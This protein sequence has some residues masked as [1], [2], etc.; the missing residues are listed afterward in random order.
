MNSMPLRSEY[1]HQSIPELRAGKVALS[2]NENKHQHLHLGRGHCTFP[3]PIPNISSQSLQSVTFYLNPQLG[4]EGPPSSVSQSLLTV[5]GRRRVAEEQPSSI[6]IWMSLLFT[7]DWNQAQTADPDP[8]SMAIKRDHLV[9][10][11]LLLNYVS[12]P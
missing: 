11:I 1:N 7:R 3:C 8:I 12:S 9:C 2:P 6:E 4:F 5:Y 10:I